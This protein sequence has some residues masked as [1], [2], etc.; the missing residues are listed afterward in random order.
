MSTEVVIAAVS[1]VAISVIG[2]CIVGSHRGPEWGFGVAA[3]GA[4]LA[5][6]F[7]WAEFLP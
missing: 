2:G 7:P 6:L 4:I 5:F 3:A 1:V